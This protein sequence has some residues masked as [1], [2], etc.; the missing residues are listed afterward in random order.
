MTVARLQPDFFDGLRVD[1]P[2]GGS[3]EVLPYILPT[4]D[5]GRLGGVPVQLRRVRI[6]YLTSALAAAA[7]TGRIRIGS[8]TSI[9]K[10]LRARAYVR[11][12]AAATRRSLTTGRLSINHFYTSANAAGIR[13]PDELELRT[14]TTEF[15][16]SDPATFAFDYDELVAVAA[17]A[18][19]L[20]YEGGVYLAPVDRDEDLAASVAPLEFVYTRTALAGDVDRAIVLLHY[21]AFPRGA[22][23][24]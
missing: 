9:L 24:L 6:A 13:L 18:S 19:D 10:I 23:I 21:L 8:K 4:A 17:S 1:V 5:V 20:L 2:P 22:V 11:N 7:Y 14:D 3:I 12:S 16:G 15:A